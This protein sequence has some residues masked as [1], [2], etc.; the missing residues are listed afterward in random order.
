M[1]PIQ[2]ICKRVGERTGLLIS[3]LTVNQGFNYV[4]AGKDT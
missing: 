2:W 1:S 4:R 3:Y